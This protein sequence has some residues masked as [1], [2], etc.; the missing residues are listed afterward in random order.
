[1]QVRFPR[2]QGGS[3]LPLEEEVSRGIS[4]YACPKK[5]L[6]LP[7]VKV[8]VPEDL[9]SAKHCAGLLNMLLLI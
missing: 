8:A 1:M 9:P 7:A 3:N 4:A 5:A 6:F 2:G